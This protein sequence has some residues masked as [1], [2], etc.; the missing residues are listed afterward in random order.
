MQRLIESGIDWLKGRSD[1]AKLLI[2]VGAVVV[3]ILVAFGA[4]AALLSN[5]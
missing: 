4:A 5:F 3:T 1:N 2:F